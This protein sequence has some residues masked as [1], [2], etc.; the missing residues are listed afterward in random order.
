MIFDFLK[1]LDSFSEVIGDDINTFGD[2]T[3]YIIDAIFA[4]VG[5]LPTAYSNNLVKAEDKISVIPALNYLEVKIDSNPEQTLFKQRYCILLTHWIDEVKIS[6]L[7][8]YLNKVGVLF[9]SSVRSL[10]SDN[11]KDS[12][13]MIAFETMKVTLEIFRRIQN[14]KHAYSGCS[15]N[16]LEAVETLRMINEGINYN[17]LFESIYEV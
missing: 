4:V 7:I 15:S 12:D 14:L 6:T 3:D 16:N 17:H 11:S 1:S 10:T 9:F 13:P 5:L 2:K 8:D